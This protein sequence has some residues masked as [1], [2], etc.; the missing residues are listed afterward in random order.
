MKK[1]VHPVKPSS[2]I[3]GFQEDVLNEKNS[4]TRE[5]KLFKAMN[6]LR[7]EADVIN[8]YKVTRLGNDFKIS[9]DDGRKVTWSASNLP[10]DWLE[11]LWQYATTYHKVNTKSLSIGEKLHNEPGQ[12]F[13]S[14]ACTAV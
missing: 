4:E 2:K 12:L 10:V 8:D 11:V 5:R 13:D 9:F 14:K 3:S 6:S 1:L 7:Q